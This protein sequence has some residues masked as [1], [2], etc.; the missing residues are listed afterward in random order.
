[1]NNTLCII[2]SKGSSVR[3]PNKNVRLFFGHPLVAYAIRKAIKANIFDKVLV[4]T[5]CAEI[6]SMSQEYGAWIPF[7][8]PIALSNDPYTIVDVVK[9][10]VCKLSSIEFSF[11]NICVLL[12]TSPLSSVADIVEA[13]KIFKMSSADA[14]M[15]VVENEYPPYNAWLID[16]EGSRKRLFHCFPESK[17]VVTKSTECPSTYRSNG[18]IMFYSLNSLLEKNHYKYMDIV[19]YVMPRENSVDIDTLMDFKYAEYLVDSGIVE[20][21]GGLFDE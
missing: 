6:A 11:D 20:L 3:F 17:Y 5:E 19:P 7:M 21:Q 16:N 12:P 10:V 8:R 14:L 2:P 15:S 18:A 1:M 13:F 4:S 9:D